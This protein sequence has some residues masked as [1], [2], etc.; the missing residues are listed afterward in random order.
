MGNNGKYLYI[1]R[2]KCCCD[3]R[4][5]LILD[6]FFVHHLSVHRYKRQWKWLDSRILVSSCKI[7]FLF[8]FLCTIRDNSCLLVRH[9]SVLVLSTQRWTVCPWS[10]LTQSLSCISGPKVFAR[11]RLYTSQTVSWRTKQ[12]PW[13][14]GPQEWSYENSYFKIFLSSLGIKM[15][16]G[17][18][19]Y[20]FT[21]NV[22]LL[23]IALSS[24]WFNLSIS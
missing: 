7:K 18:W 2:P 15:G 20:C 3:I 24:P 4:E 23:S 21:F 10:G 9:P 17:I 22:L 19:F 13:N 8:L 5:K 1:F 12:N 6:F 11:S 14:F 16:I